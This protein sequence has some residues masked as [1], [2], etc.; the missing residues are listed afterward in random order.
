M[1]EG[2]RVTFGVAYSI[3][4]LPWLD[5]N[6]TFSMLRHR[7]EKRRSIKNNLPMIL[8]VL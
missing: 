2:D 1:R 4:R 8:N 5:L 6:V 3:Y 7:E